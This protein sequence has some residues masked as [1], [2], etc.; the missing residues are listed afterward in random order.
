[1][2]IKVRVNLFLEHS[3]K[4]WFSVESM[5]KCEVTGI[6]I[7]MCPI[8]ESEGTRVIF[9]GGLRRGPSTYC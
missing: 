3:R 1:M 9:S 6:T 7:R 4:L 2:I 8:N 5:S